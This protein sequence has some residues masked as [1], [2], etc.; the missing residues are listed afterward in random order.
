M[1]RPVAL[2]EARDALVEFCKSLMASALDLV[3]SAMACK[4][5]FSQILI[6][7]GFVWHSE[8]YIKTRMDQQMGQV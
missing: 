7:A 8:I 3:Q 1:H 4:L 5:C 2:L 6:Q